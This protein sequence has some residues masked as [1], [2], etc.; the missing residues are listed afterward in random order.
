MYPSWLPVVRAS[1]IAWTPLIPCELPEGPTF[2]NN[3]ITRDRKIVI[4]V[5]GSRF[6]T[7]KSSLDRF[8]DTLLG[9]DEK[10]YFKDSKSGEYFFDRDPNLFRFILAYYRSGKLHFPKD[11]CVTAYHD[12]LIYFGIMPE[13]MGDCCYEEY[14]DRYRENRER[15]LEDLNDHK[16][17]EQPATCFRE[18]LWRAF[19]NPQAS[20]L[21]I[22]L[23]YVTGF[24]IGVSVLANVTETVSCG[25]SQETGDNIPCGEKYNAA[26]F[27]LDTACVMLFTIEYFAR[28]YAAPSRWKFIRSVMSIID[29]AAVLPYYIGLFMSNN[30]E[31]SGAF[32]TLRVFRV[33]R[34]FKFSRHSKG[35]RILGCTL[36]CCASELGFLLFTITMG[37]IIFST[38]MFYAEKSETSQF[39]SIPAAFWY[40]IVTMTTL[41][42]G[43]IVP[44]TIIGK[45]FGGICSL[46]GVL[47]IALPVPVIV[48]HFARI[49]Q[50]NQR[51]D[52]RE[53]QKK[54]RFSRINEMKMATETA[55]L[56]GKRRFEMSHDDPVI[57]NSPSFHLEKGLQYIEEEAGCVGPGY[58]EP[59]LMEKGLQLEQNFF[60]NERMDLFEE[61]Y[62]HLIDCLQRTT[63]CDVISSELTGSEIPFNTCGS[64]KLRGKPSQKPCTQ[65]S[66]AQS[67]QPRH[68]E[69][70]RR[71][72]AVIRRLR[73]SRRRLGHCHVRQAIER[74]C[75]R[76]RRKSQQSSPKAVGKHSEVT[77]HEA[78]ARKR[79]SMSDTNEENVRGWLQEHAG[80][81][82]TSL[83]E[84][85]SIENFIGTESRLWQ[86]NPRLTKNA[87]PDDGLS[88]PY[89]SDSRSTEVRPVYPEPLEKPDARWS[90]S[91]STNV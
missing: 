90:T 76:R 64:I 80:D 5:S 29:I 79:A 48:S 15:Q 33:C 75:G 73:F 40:T 83:C 60:E 41:G 19:E 91:R 30:K 88:F 89:V 63:G 37:V 86:R 85:V 45:I 13:I 53:A 39:N 52:K 34:I 18:Q 21:A 14:L 62:Y 9:S 54:A 20:T 68:K 50:Q 66:I 23:Y 32:T 65:K 17:E 31:F 44:I 59:E 27:C 67:T 10:D 4:N 84:R 58:T 56:E 51:N 25:T 77:E 71:S 74:C 69:N 46:S 16:E 81:Q 24:F 2:S 22:V 1:A 12:E 78:V 70:S 47:V 8:P 72:Y 57:G 42:Y 7:W 38:I 49:Y 87:P 35:L 36:R 28:L 43:D 82:R 6:E 55:F 61:Q 3:V 26:F 11:S